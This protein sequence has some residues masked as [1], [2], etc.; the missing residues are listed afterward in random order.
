[1]FSAQT[2]TDRRN[3]LIHQVESGLILL[4]G[5]EESGM[6]YADNT[7]HFRQ[8]SHFLY[9]TGLETASL[10]AI[11]DVDNGTTTIFGDELSIDVA[12][13]SNMM[14]KFGFWRTQ[15][16]NDIEQTTTN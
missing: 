4:L 1:M 3:Q 8:D 2:Y 5:N 11:I 14:S 7:Y 6:N 10:A 16:R 15:N 9:Y 12:I 13:A